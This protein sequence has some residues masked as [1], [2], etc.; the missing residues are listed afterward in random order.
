MP[1]HLIQRSFPTSWVSIFTLY[2]SPV[3]IDRGCIY[4]RP[5]VKETIL[6]GSPGSNRWPYRH[7]CCPCR[8]YKLGGALDDQAGPL[9]LAVVSLQYLHQS[10]VRHPDTT[11][12]VHR[13]VSGPAKTPLQQARFTAE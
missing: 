5:K 7:D 12:H 9:G 11:L 1:T 8:A 6:H 10:T 3:L 2:I 13:R 4:D